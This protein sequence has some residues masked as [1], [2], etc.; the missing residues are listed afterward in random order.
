MKR[1][2]CE[3]N[4]S[5]FIHYLKKET[6]DIAYEQSTQLSFTWF[7]GVFDLFFDKC[8][9]KRSFKVTYQNRYPWMTNDLRTRITTKNK[10]GYD[11]FRDTEKINL[12]N[13]YTQKRN[14]LISDLRNMEIEYNSNEL[15]LNKSDI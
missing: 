2:F 9:K 4:V 14:R 12:K 10:L 13:E 5:Q 3:R 7:Q 15:E 1:S 8:F 6:W 11:V